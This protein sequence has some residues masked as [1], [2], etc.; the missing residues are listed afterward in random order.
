M[1]DVFP[2]VLYALY[3]LRYLKQDGSKS[4]TG[5]LKPDTDN[6][7]DL[8]AVDLAFAIAF[9][10]AFG[11][12]IE[13]KDL[14]PDSDAVRLIGSAIKQYLNGYFSQLT[15]GGVTRSSW[16]AAGS[17]SQSMDDVYNNGSVVNVDNTDEVHKLSA[18][19]HFKLTNAAGTTILLDV[20]GAGNVVMSFVNREIA[21]S[22]NPKSFSQAV[23]LN[24]TSSGSNGIQVV[25]NDNIDVGCGNYSLVF[26]GSIPDWTPGEEIFL[27]R[28]YQNDN[29]CFYFEI[30]P[31]NYLRVY[32]G[33]DGGT[34]Q[35]GTYTSTELPIIRDNAVAEIVAVVTRETALVAGSV[36][37]YVNGLQ[38]G[39]SLPIPAQTVR[40]INNTGNLSILGTIGSCH[41]GTCSFAAMFNRA[42]SALEVYD[43]FLNGIANV[44]KWGSQTELITNGEVWTGATGSTPPTGWTHAASVSTPTFTIVDLSAVVGLDSATLQ[45]AVSAGGYSEIIE[46]NKYVVG[47]KFTTTIA[48]RYNKA[49]GTSG[50]IRPG[51]VLHNFTNTGL[52]GDAVVQTFEDVAVDTVIEIVLMA[53]DTLQIAYVRVVEIGATL[54]LEAG[55]IQPAPGQW[56][57]S[58]TNKNHALQPAGPSS[59][60]CRKKDFEI[61]WTNTWTGTHEAQHI[62]G[63]NQNILPSDNIYIQEIIGVITGATIEDIIVGDGSDADRFVAITTGLAAGTVSFT[64]A[65]KNHDGT[66][67][68]M[69][70]DPDANFTGSIAWTIRGIILQ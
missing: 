46:Y 2:S 19:K 8:G 38:L 41:A 33:G 66:N 63:I 51:G 65:N 23:H 61:R 52:S 28:K 35:P 53:G 30:T 25:D 7:R 24:A 39:D 47:K 55:G 4:L 18:T 60:L 5:D 1:S 50:S 10:K 44:D 36:V 37:F 43:L 70:V 11:L 20:D 59:L 67:Q 12:P 21:A 48:Y 9:I 16:P 15:L 45:Y 69:V 68:K 42:L 58:S 26:R 57:D 62:G 64:I 29:H 27:L 32:M 54:A 34:Y 40:N 49:G 22:A 17:G 3:D 31:T 13:T 6:T 56:L 14:T